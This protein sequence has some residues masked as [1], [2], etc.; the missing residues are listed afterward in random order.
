MWVFGYG[1]LMTDGW[2]VRHNCL[3]RHIAD[4]AGYCRVFNKASVRNWRTKTAPGL[5][6]N[7]AK[8]ESGIC[9][10]VAFEFADD[11]SG[12]VLKELE[13]REGRNFELTLLP[14]KLTDGRSVRAIVPL[15]AGSNI[16]ELKT[17]DEMVQMILRAKGEK[18]ICADYVKQVASQ[19]ERLGI[20]DAAVTSLEKA[21]PA[22]K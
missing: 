15:Y 8:T 19:L 4:L 7:L 11:Q 6:L 14:V 10:G 3:G 16:V 21:I 17:I 5:T 22:S 13:E 18:G 1:S 20:N 2:E 12:A 9:R